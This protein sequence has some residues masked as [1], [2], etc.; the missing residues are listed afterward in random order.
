M[1]ST[2][3]FS[4]VTKKPLTQDVWELDFMVDTSL[5]SSLPVTTLVSE[6]TTPTTS[7]LLV[8]P[9]QYILFILPSGLRRAYSIGYSF[10]AEANYAHEHTIPE[11]T[12]IFR[13]II[14]RLD[15]VGA[16]SQ[17]VCDIAVGGTLKGM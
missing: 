16:G 7:H 6:T 5:D 3:F 9:G 14:K 15:H 4:L 11:G 17:E 10:N 8:H 12:Q 13:F 2:S 1:I